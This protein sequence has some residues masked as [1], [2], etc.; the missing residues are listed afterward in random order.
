MLRNIF[1]LTRVFLTGAFHRGNGAK[2]GKGRIILY[3]ILFL[4]VGVVFSILSYE[5]IESLVAVS[6]EEAFPALVFMVIISMTLMTSI[7]LCLNVFYFSKDNLF[8]LPLPLKPQEVLSAKFNTLLIYTYIE[9]LTF[10]LAPMI[11]YG[12]LTSRGFLFYL[13]LLPVFFLLPVLPL[14]VVT[15][16]ILGLMAITKGIRNK[17][18]VQLLTTTLAIVFSLLV[19]M[20]SSSIG[21]QEEAMIMLEK[22]NG[23]A[24]LYAKTFFSMPFALSAIN[25][26]SFLSLL[27]L[28]VISV[29]AYVLVCL[30]GEKLYYRGMLGSLF[31][32]SG[33]SEKKLDEKAYRSRGKHFT[34]FAKEWRVYLRKPAFFTQLILPSLLMPPVMVFILR[35]SLSS[36]GGNVMEILV[37]FYEMKEFAP[38]VFGALLLAAVFNCFYCFVSIVAVSKDG[39]DAYMMKYIPMAFYEQLIVKAA[40]DVFLCLTAFL[41]SLVLAV[42]LMKLPLRMALLALP[43]GVLNSL[44]HGLLVLVDVRH[45]KLNWTSEM[46]VAKNNLMMIFSF[47]FSLF[48]GALIA[49]LAF[50]IGAKPLF[51]ISGMCLLDLLICVLG[52]WYLYK[53]DLKLADH[54]E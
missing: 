14:A 22:A 47:A 51:M 9:E 28:L 48:H 46:Q 7:A 32:S 54:F 27:G 25:R 18:L 11:L 29:A 44:A 19:S 13:F 42:F 38:Y 15:F 43:F 33:I 36:S 40:V 41:V 53:K 2:S 20:F 35:F 3:A 23:I 12:V 8:V 1:S 50:V 37:Q 24:E 5:L 52:Y 17:N 39:K 26:G 49:V 21:S 34:Y 4:Y 6:Q 31:S 45:P 10:A 30:F 16:I